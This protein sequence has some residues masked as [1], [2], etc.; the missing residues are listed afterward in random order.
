MKRR[1]TSVMSKTS[2]PWWRRGGVRPQSR[3]RSEGNGFGLP[4][5]ETRDWTQTS[6]STR[7]AQ[8]VGDET[9]EKILDE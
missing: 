1:N 7:R 2:T 9:T 6:L 3:E 5:G 8:K 4:V